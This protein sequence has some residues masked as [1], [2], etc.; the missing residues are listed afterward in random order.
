MA[1]ATGLVASH[2]DTLYSARARARLGYDLGDF[3]PFVAAGVATNEFAQSDVAPLATGSVRRATGWTAGAGLDWKVALPVLGNSVLRAEYVYEAYPST[4]L[5]LNAGPVQS[6]LSTQ[7]VRVALIA[8]IGDRPAPAAP[9]G[10]DQ[11]DWS[12][13]YGGALAG[14]GALQAKTMAPGTTGPSLNATGPLGGILGGRNFTFGPWVAGFEGST[15][16]T[17]FTGNGRTPAS[18]DD[19][20]LRNYIQADLRG[21]VGYAFGRFLPYF[22]AGLTWGL[23]EQRDQVTLAEIGRIPSQAWAAGAGL[24]Y[25]LTDRLSLRGEYL[26]ASTYSNAWTSL[27]PCNACSQSLTGSMVRVGMAYYFH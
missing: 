7:F 22:A 1:A 3:L 8:R 13:A 12:G 26:F 10:T 20:T 24:E 18:A 23:S 9:A 16:M 5:A 4:A 11:V 19:M 17:G 14:F 6:R 21:R 15:M 2:V 27:P 25:M